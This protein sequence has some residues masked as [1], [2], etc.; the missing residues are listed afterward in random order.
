MNQL[1]RCYCECER[2]TT[3]WYNIV[4]WNERLGKNGAQRHPMLQKGGSLVVS[5]PRCLI[6]QIAVTFDEGDR[7][8]CE[9]RN[10]PSDRASGS[11]SVCLCV[12]SLLLLMCTVQIQLCPPLLNKSS[13]KYKLCCLQHFQTP[14]ALCLRC[15]CSFDT[16]SSLICS[17]YCWSD[18]PPARSFHSLAKN[19][20]NRMLR[21]LTCK[22]VHVGKPGE[23]EKERESKKRKRRRVR[24]SLRGLVLYSAGVSWLVAL[25]INVCVCVWVRV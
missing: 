4:L 14:A 12:F 2:L 22:H 19:A 24:E 6:S 25:Q 21:T 13:F 20:H 1:R 18:A 9:E 11:A 16:V 17:T 3:T 7:G 8:R 5:N 10:R 15:L 23:K